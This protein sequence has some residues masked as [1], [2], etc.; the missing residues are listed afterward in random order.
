MPV[1][2]TERTGLI[3]ARAGKTDVE[4]QVLRAH[5]AH[6]RACG[7]NITLTILMPV[8]P[9]SSPRVRGK[10]REG[11]HTGLPARLI[12]ARAGKTRTA[13]TWAP[14]AWA[15]PRACGENRRVIS[16]MCMSRG[17]SPRVRGKHRPSVGLG[18]PDGLIPARAGKTAGCSAVSSSGTAHPLTGQE[19]YGSSPR[20][21]GKR[22]HAHQGML[23]ARLIPARA[24]KTRCRLAAGRQPPA[25]PRACGENKRA[26]NG[27]RFMAGSSPR[28]RGKP[29]P[30]T[31]RFT[32]RR[33]I[34]ARAGKTASSGDG[35]R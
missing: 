23:G 19:P 31:T 6:P 22:E 10:L 16:S 18:V 9:G 8:A 28:V 15:H 14:T 7:E 27:Y 17:S 21:R 11:D 32:S 24:G 13:W 29:I 35:I 12:P 34:P 20:V 30:A 4:R 26:R 25:H 5:R 3:P 33:L 2:R 1:V